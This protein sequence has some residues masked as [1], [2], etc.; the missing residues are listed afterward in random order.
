MFPSALS[1]RGSAKPAAPA[2]GNAHADVFHQLAYK[3]ERQ[4]FPSHDQRTGAGEHDSRTHPIRG[5]ASG[6]K[7]ERGS[8]GH[9][10]IVRPNG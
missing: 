8:L 1:N 7:G 9:A 4:R 2:F 6:T 10:A 5:L 3:L